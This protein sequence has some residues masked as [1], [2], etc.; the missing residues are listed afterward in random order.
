M[1]D[2][3][4]VSWSAAGARILRDVTLECPPR[5]VVGL[6]G[7]NGAGKTS[8]LRCIY[9]VLRPDAGVIRLDGDSVWEL[10][11]RATARR[12]AVV[13]QESGGELGFTVREMVLMGRSPHK[14]WHETDSAADRA[15]VDRALDQ[16]D[17]FGLA[18][19]GFGTLSGGEKQRAL[20]AR[21]LAQEPRFLVLDEPTAH[22]DIRHQLEMLE[23][24]RGLE[25]TTIAA[26][27]DLNLAALFCDR[28]YVLH[29]GRIVAS[30]APADVLTVDLIRDVYGVAAEV[31]VHRGRI[32]V[33]FLP[34]FLP[35][36]PP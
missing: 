16:V 14:A 28:L 7:P 20:V 5:T 35:A 25:L 21:A 34:A 19:R 1:L 12:M 27:H 36:S 6:I 24:I 30:G 32:Q 17:L 3:H 31:M 18:D 15:I 9:R 26:L 4:E 33:V 22:L 11:A 10:S 13:P 8:L 2:V 29:E 23:L